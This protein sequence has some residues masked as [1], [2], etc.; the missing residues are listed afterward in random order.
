MGKKKGGKGKKEKPEDGLP[1]PPDLDSQKEG[2]REALL[3]FRQVISSRAYYK[4]C[5]LCTHNSLLF[6]LYRIQGKEDSILTYE[7]EAENFKDRNYRQKEK[8]LYS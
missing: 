8:V 5:Q 1:P 3:T 6:L 2:A 7:E 4:F